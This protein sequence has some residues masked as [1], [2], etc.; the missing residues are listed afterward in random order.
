MG[1]WQGLARLD[2]AD[3]ADAELRAA[4]KPVEAFLESV[5]TAS[6]QPAAEVEA[7]VANLRAALRRCVAK[8]SKQALASAEDAL[9]SA[10][11][12]AAG[13]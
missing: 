12:A 11:D 9:A 3:E 13:G 8:A 6:A 5:D 1:G 2:E 7:A 10:A 4:T